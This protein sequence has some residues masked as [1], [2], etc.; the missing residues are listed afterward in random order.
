MAAI[1]IRDELDLMQ[2]AVAELGMCRIAGWRAGVGMDGHQAVPG[3][4][5]TNTSF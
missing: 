5:R 4:Q 2:V 3:V 1:R